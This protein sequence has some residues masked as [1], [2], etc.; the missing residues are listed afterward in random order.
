MKSYLKS[1]AW[2]WT[3]PV[4]VDQ[5]GGYSLVSG[6]SQQVSRE[7]GGAIFR[8]SHYCIFFESH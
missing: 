6:F 7:T 8:F 5:S 4:L 3:S 1:I 2:T